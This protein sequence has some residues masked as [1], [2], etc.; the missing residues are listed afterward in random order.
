MS[1]AQALATPTT[2]YGLY[3]YKNKGLGG[4]WLLDLIDSVIL[5]TVTDYPCGCMENLLFPPNQTHT[6][7][8]MSVSQTANLPGLTS[9]YT[10]LQEQPRAA[11]TH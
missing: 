9:P 2:Q 5:L 10:P 6:L 1:L 8:S 11:H 3:C 7:H 4:I